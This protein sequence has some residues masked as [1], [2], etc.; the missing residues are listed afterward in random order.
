MKQAQQSRN[1]LLEQGTRIAQNS[2]LL[3]ILQLC[4]TL[5]ARLSRHDIRATRPVTCTALLP[6][7]RLCRLQCHLQQHWQHRC[8][9]CRA[10]SA[11]CAAQ[12]PVFT[13]M[14]FSKFAI[15]CTLHQC[16][17]GLSTNKA[18]SNSVCNSLEGTCQSEHVLCQHP[19]GTRI[20][21][22]WASMPICFLCT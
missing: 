12:C 7:C 22:S 11:S 8:Q 9:Q 4:I 1:I 15:V 16:S 18:C 2:A 3:C 5:N 6:S 10:W 19:R 21:W 17:N 14:G 13:S 20:I